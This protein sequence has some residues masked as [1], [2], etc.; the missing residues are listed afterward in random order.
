VRRA[1]KHVAVS[2]DENGR[3]RI[4]NFGRGTGWLGASLTDLGDVTGI[5]L[6]PAAVE[7]AKREFTARRFMVG[8]L[9]EVLPAGPST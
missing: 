7:L 3:L 6:A 1:A 5:D 8:S 9:S 2:I 4:V